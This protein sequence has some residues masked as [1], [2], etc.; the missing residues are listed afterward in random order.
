MLV[1]LILIE[2]CKKMEHYIIDLFKT[3]FEN[4]SKLANAVYILDKSIVQ[5]Y[6]LDVSHYKMF[7]YPTKILKC[8]NFKIKKFKYFSL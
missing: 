3:I 4:Y 6:Y 5:L 1:T 8:L 2:P 7:S